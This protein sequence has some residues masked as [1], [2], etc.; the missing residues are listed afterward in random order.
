MAENTTVENNPSVTPRKKKGMSFALSA[1]IVGFGVI[2]VKFSGLIRDIVVSMKFSDVYRDS[3]ILAFNI[4]D[5]FYNLLV[6][7]AIYSTIAPYL[8]A[9]LAIGKEKEAIKTVSKFITAVCLVML[10]CCTFGSLFSEPL[11]NFY[12]LFHKENA[13]TIALAAQASKLLF[14]Q[15][16]FIMLAALCNGILISYRKFT[17][18]SFAP[19]FYNVFVIAAIFVFGGNS[20][21]NLLW[22]TGGVNFPPAIS[23]VVQRRFK[24]VCIA[25]AT[26][27]QC[28]DIPCD[29]MSGV[30]VHITTEVGLRKVVDTLIGLYWILRFYR[31]FP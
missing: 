8:S 2:L 26:C 23:H 7:G 5:L 29:G 10:V 3:Y 30:V 28:I 6:G 31:L 11:Y 1:I 24:T 21:K 4:P 18:T 12:G 16:F 20:L 14:P 15:I 25:A 17:I 27:A 19:I 9:H 22:T 13:E